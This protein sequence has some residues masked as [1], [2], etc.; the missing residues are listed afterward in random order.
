MEIRE[1]RIEDYER[2]VSLWRDAGL[3]FRPRGRDRRE[4]IERELSGAGAIFLIAEEQERLVGSVLGTHDGR[5]G[6]I[7]RLAV[8]PSHR[9]SGV[10]RALVGEAERRL[11]ERGIGIIACLIEDGNDVS[12]AFFRELGYARYPEIVYHAKRLYP[13]V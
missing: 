1:L 9:R 6:W 13:E 4:A 11:R 12:E 8:L 10:A 2:L 3:P 5:K 7:N